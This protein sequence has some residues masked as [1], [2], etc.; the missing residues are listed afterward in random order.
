[1]SMTLKEYLTAYLA[2]YREMKTNELNVRDVY[3]DIREYKMEILG[4]LDGKF[5][6]K[7]ET[8]YNCLKYQYIYS[9]GDDDSDDEW[10]IMDFLK[11]CQHV[12]DYLNKHH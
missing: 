12:L 7:F 9:F 11:I 3:F 1:M 10:I 4:V 8:E 6:E 2:K 5:R